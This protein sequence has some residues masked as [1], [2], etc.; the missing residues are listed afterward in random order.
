MEV[1]LYTRLRGERKFDSLDDLRCEILR[2]A[3]Q[4]RAFFAGREVEG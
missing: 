2:N 3:D 1:E 4:T